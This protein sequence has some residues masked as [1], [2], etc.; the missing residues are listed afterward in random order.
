MTMRYKTLSIAGFDGSGGAGIQ[1][2]LKTFSAFGC[3]GM[4]VLTALPVQNTRGVKACYEL[5]LQAIDDQLHT[6]FEDIRPDSIKIGMLFKRDIIELVA[7]FLRR[8]AAGIPIVLDPVLVAKSGDR[9]LL[10]DAL[11]TMRSVLIPLATVITPN[12]P[13]AWA[14]IGETNS[15]SDNMLELARKLI[16]LGP[17]NVLLKGGHLSASHSNDLLLNQEGE[18]CW[19][20]GTRI[21]SKNTHGTGCTLSAAISA[22]LALGIEL[23]EACKIAK[24]YVFGAIEAAKN[25]QIG[26]GHGPVHHFYNIW[27]KLNFYKP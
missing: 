12:L 1:A 25:E 9:L 22:C 5:P 26:L 2:D 16:K 21:N 18:F 3:Y 14:L 4:T 24:N 7:H 13:E 8:Y 11:D 15:A 10:P 20:E 27:P 6:I 17:Q 23:K 19:L